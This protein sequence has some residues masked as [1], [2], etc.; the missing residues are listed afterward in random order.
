[1]SL[2]IEVSGLDVTRAGRSILSDFNLSVAA[3]ERLAITGP[4]GVGKSTLLLAI[5]G[6]IRLNGGQVCLGGEIVL[7]PSA[8]VA[9]MQ[10]RPALLPW[11]T[12]MGNVAL[13]LKFAG[14]PRKF[15]QERAAALLEQVGLADRA[16]A[17]PHELSGGQ[18][19]RIALARSLAHK[20]AAL[21]LDEPFSALDAEMRASLRDDVARMADATGV[22]V[23]LVTHH[24]GDADALCHR[25]ITLSLPPVAGLVPSILKAA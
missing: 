21:L 10:Q 8:K 11:A 22:T 18:Q 19:Q 14:A 23:L 15:Q 13:A 7:K 12:A 1:V 2:P 16:G 20:P 5:A 25:Q 4:S 17:M 9:L 6:L 24:Q 3:G